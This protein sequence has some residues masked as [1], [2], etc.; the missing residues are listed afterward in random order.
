[1]LLKCLAGVGT[2]N[3]SPK[4]LLY[5]PSFEHGKIICFSSILTLLNFRFALGT[6]TQIALFFTALAKTPPKIGGSI[7]YHESRNK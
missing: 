5:Q 7:M 2:G 3:S 4:S 1:M 6:R